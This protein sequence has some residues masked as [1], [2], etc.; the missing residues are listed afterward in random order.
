MDSN[1]IKIR[2]E[3]INGFKYEKMFEPDELIRDVRFAFI[4]YCRVNG[5]MAIRH[6]NINLIYNET[7]LEDGN[8]LNHYNIQDNSLIRIVPDMNTSN[9]NRGQAI[10]INKPCEL[11][12]ASSMPLRPEHVHC[13]SSKLEETIENI[14]K[15]AMKIPKKDICLRSLIDQKDSNG[16]PHRKVVFID[17]GYAYIIGH[18]TIKE[19]SDDIIP[20]DEPK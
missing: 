10:N 20:E 4:V 18:D 12:R 1:K 7:V 6:D 14:K 19:D 8:K 13:D 15:R 2:F 5:N 3:T 16:E 17:K 9:R 11:R